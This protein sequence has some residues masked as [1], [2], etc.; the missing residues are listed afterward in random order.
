MA[1]LAGALMGA[2]EQ[3]LARAMVAGRNGLRALGVHLDEEA[4]LASARAVDPQHRRFAAA[5]QDVLLPLASRPMTIDLAQRLGLSNRQVVRLANDYFSR[6]HVTVDGWRE[7]VG[8]MRLC[9]G[10]FLSSH[11]MART[12]SIS[13]TLGFS[14][15]TALCHAFQSAGMPSPQAV[16]RRALD[17]RLPWVPPSLVEAASH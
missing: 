6:F 12:E 10:Q 13:R 2:D 15:P 11:P 9:I 14:S 8:G 5:L 17:H 3:A 1:E 4:A 7:Y 16:R